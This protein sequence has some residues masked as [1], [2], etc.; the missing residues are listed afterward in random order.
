[1]RAFI[2][3]TVLVVI[4]SALAQNVACTP[5]VPE[6]VCKQ[7]S[8]FFMRQT[9]TQVII[10]GPATFREKR[11]SIGKEF[12]ERFK[13]GL[14]RNPAM[15]QRYSE[16]VLFVR[17]NDA[18]P[19]S[20]FVSTDAFRPVKLQ[21]KMDGDTIRVEKLE[22]LE[23]FDIE[24]TRAVATYVDGFVTGCRMGVAMYLSDELWKK[25]GR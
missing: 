10:T 22:V 14:M 17:D 7:A 6:K 11:D 25:K 1:M 9:G 13:V 16:D 2:F 21:E 23:G 19:K 4:P 3:A 18:C 20:V 24:N 12:G 5:E 15:P 8:I